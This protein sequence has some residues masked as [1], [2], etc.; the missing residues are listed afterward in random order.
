MNKEYHDKEL[1]TLCQQHKKEIPDA[2]FSKNTMHHISL[3]PQ[4][5]PLWHYA[6]F[7]I[8]LLSAL[9]IM[10]AFNL[11]PS[12]EQFTASTQYGINLLTELLLSILLNKYFYITALLALFATAI[13]M[14]RKS[15]QM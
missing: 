7:V 13:I 9:F 8:S 12:I 3:Y 2:G 4:R 6:I 11:F 1:R 10:L 14:F 15:L 5:T